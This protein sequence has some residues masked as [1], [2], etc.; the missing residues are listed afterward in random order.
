MEQATQSPSRRINL[1]L[2][3]QLKDVKE[4][5][6]RATHARI[7]SAKEKLDIV[8]G[9]ASLL[10]SCETS[11]GQSELLEEFQTRNFHNDPQFIMVVKRA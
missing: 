4:Q 7:L 8:S 3:V 11:D 2:H 9:A 5:I 1:N 6:V 10:R